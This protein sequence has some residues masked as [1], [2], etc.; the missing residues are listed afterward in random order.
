MVSLDYLLELG[1]DTYYSTSACKIK[2]NM[3]MHAQYNIISV[4]WC[5]RDLELAQIHV[6]PY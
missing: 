1:N 3:L 6:P 4:Y 2:E 5:I